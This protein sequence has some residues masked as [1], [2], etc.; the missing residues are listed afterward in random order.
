MWLFVGLSG[1][2]LVSLAVGLVLGPLLASA[3]RERTVVVVVHDIELQPAHAPKPTRRR[4]RS[5]RS[6][7]ERI[8][9][10]PTMGSPTSG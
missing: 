5:S 2:L 9:P 1:W 4:T 3:A 8:L 10:G 7:W 6:F